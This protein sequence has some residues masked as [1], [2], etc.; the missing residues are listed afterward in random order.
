[1]KTRHLIVA[2]LFLSLV[3]IATALQGPSAGAVVAFALS[4]SLAMGWSNLT[5]LRAFDVAPPITGTSLATMD[6]ASVRQLWQKGV[7]TFDQQND[8]FSDMIGGPNSLVWE[9]TE[10]AAGKGSKITFTVGSGFYDEPHIGEERFLTNDDYED[11]LIGSHELVV[12]WARHGIRFSERTEELMG[13]R[14]EI[15]SRFNTEQGAWVG[16]LKTEQLLMMFVHL[17]PSD[18]VLYAG[19]TTFADLTA[20]DSLKMD[21]II[22]AGTL[23]GGMNGL[24]AMFKTVNGNTVSRNVVIATKDS[25]YSLK[26]DSNY[27]QLLRETQDAGA[28]RIPFTGGYVDVDGHIIREYRVIDHDGEGAIGSP[29]NPQARLG[30]AVAAGTGALTVKGGGNA[31]SAAK[32]KKLYFKHFPNHAYRFIGNTDPKS[33]GSFTLTKD[34]G[35]HYFLV[36]NPP[37]AATDPGK[38]G[39]YAYT[40]GNSGHDIAVTA[41]LAAG[42]GGIAVTTLGDVTWN[43]GVWSGVHTDVHPIGARI[44]PCNEKGQVFADTLMLGRRAAYRGYGKYRNTRKQD[45]KEGGMTMERYVVSVFGQSLRKDRL[46][47]VPGVIRLRHAVQLPGVK[48]PEV[49]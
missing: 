20:G 37:N 18:N 10:V 13:M 8:F 34:A 9:K 29:L 32:T 27:Q 49:V 15:A 39:M 5:I 26:R 44:Y 23:M 12:D 48:L 2:V 21:D 3:A 47:R 1:M 43:T 17:L 22:G 6:E 28:S 41:R 42:A 14:G 46:D 36:V 11:Y 38:I 19:D 4:A 7:D 31:T 40:T 16:R 24:P 25:L 30:V 35:T 45:E 33:D